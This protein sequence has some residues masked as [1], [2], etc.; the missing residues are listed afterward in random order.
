MDLSATPT[1][2]GRAISVLSGLL[3]VARTDCASDPLDGLSNLVRPVLRFRLFDAR[4]QRLVAKHLPDPSR[5]VSGAQVSL[6]ALG[7]PVSA[8]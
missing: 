7:S 2:F 8:R 4:C 1:K 5:E 6:N 3:V